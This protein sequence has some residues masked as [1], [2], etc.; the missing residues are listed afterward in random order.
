MLLEL[1][2]LLNTIPPDDYLDPD[3]P[4]KRDEQVVGEMDNILRRAY[5][6]KMRAAAMALRKAA[7]AM[8]NSHLDG[9]AEHLKNLAD[10]ANDCFWHIVRDRLQLWD[11]EGI[12]VRSGFRVVVKED[13]SD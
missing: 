5:T 10:I 12:G 4:V 6:L 9:E 1:N 11:K 3:T 13:S 8:T 7:D 2:D